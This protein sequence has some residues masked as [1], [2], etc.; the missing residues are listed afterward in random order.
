MSEQPAVN[1]RAVERAIDVLAN[2]MRLYIEA[3]LR[4]G[5]LFDIDREE[6]VN[7]LD[8]GFEVKL[9]AFH[10][11]Y[12]A[13][14]S[15]FP[16]ADFGD[17]ALLI[18]VRNALHHQNAPMFHSLLSRLYL[19]D[20]LARWEGAAFLLA[21]HPTRHGGRI[22]MSHPIRLD[23]IDARLD[24]DRAAPELDTQQKGQRAIR[25]FAVINQGL[26][27]PAIRQ[28][29]ALERYP[30]DQVYVDLMPVFTS[31]VV[32]VFKA[33]RAAGVTFRGHDARTY[34]EPF[35]SEIEVDLQNP[36]FSALKIGHAPFWSAGR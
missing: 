12:D 20:G 9:N 24:P 8:R 14:R 3:N 17:T 31:A 30:A 27:L 6:A 21:R 26:A 28:R 5:G 34:L 10:S 19:A 2:T 1:T 11:L 13:S 35:T 36:T 18:A 29:G 7:N 32:R 16:Y 15:L 23:E 4:F 33:L 25:R 22:S